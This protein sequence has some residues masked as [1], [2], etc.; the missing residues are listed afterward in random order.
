MDAPSSNGAATEEEMTQSDDNFKVV[1]RIRP[2]LSRELR[3]TGLRPYQ[4]TTYVEPTGRILTLSENL[5]AAISGNNHNAA[6]DS[7]LFA[8][9]RFTFDHVYDQS[10]S[11]E[12]LYTKSA[13]HIVLSI[14][15]GYNAAIIA[16]GQTGTGKTYTMEGEIQGDLRG[17]IPRTV[18]DIFTY[19]VNDPEPS[20]KYLVRAS[21]LQIYN[22]VISDMLKPERTNLIIR[23][24]R[25]RGV[26]V[27]GLSEWVVRSPNEV[28]QLMQRGQS[29][30]INGNEVY[31][32]MQRGQSMRATGATKLNEVSSRSHAVCIIIVEKCVS[33]SRPGQPMDLSASAKEGSYSVKVG[34]LNLVDLA[35]SERVHVTGAVGKRLEESKKINASLSALGNVIAALT[36]RGERS[37][38]PYRDS[39]LTRIL[40]DSLGGNCR[41]TM[42][43]TVAPAMDAF[44]ES[45]STLKFANRAKNI[46][47]EAHVNEDLD[48]RTLLR[49]YE[50]ELR[51]LKAELQRRSR[52]LVDKRALF[53]VEEQKKRAEADKLAALTALEKRSREFLREKEEKRQ[54]EAKIQAMQSQMLVGGA[55]LEDVPAFRAILAREHRRIRDEYE[56]R[57]KELETERQAVEEDRQQVDRYKQLLLKQRDIMIALTARLNERDDQINMLQEELEAYD[58]Y[59]RQLEDT[60]D[61]RTAEIIALRRAALEMHP[62]GE[63]EDRSMFDPA[64]VTNIPDKTSSF[65]AASVSLLGGSLQTADVI[66]LVLEGDPGSAKYLSQEGGMSSSSGGGAAAGAGLLDSDFNGGRGSEGGA[67]KQQTVF[68]MPLTSQRQ[69]SQQG[70]PPASDQ[71]SM[72]GG[73]QPVS[74][75]AENP[76]GP[77][78]L[79]R[80]SALLQLRAENARLSGRLSAATAALQAATEAADNRKQQH[81][82][83]GHVEEVTVNNEQDAERDRDRVVLLTSACLAAQKERSALHQILESKVRRMMEE[84]IQEVQQQG[85][86]GP[87]SAG[88]TYNQHQLVV[89][90]R[91][92]EQVLMKVGEAIRLAPP[93]LPTE[94]DTYV[95]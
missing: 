93:I 43:C 58:K 12:E 33:T 5:Q 4:C 14:L 7:M 85:M 78:A 51:R 92:M 49:K 32:L 86:G 35:G 24:D 19:I 61:G 27:D 62:A 52:D 50:K 90:L 48:Q 69:L 89:R 25:R 2:P 38:V 60:L 20:S 77:E 30:T 83:I 36:A 63:G 88:T 53:E 84:T 76:F 95:E 15:Q 29:M 16:Y 79:E 21:Y 1:I 22:E 87:A 54:L 10:S 42:I 39:K 37:H 67:L 23:E 72:K 55:K 75:A 11:Q 70:F 73:R 6:P 74:I 57:L 18:E 82:S 13:Q 8:T 46:K 41:T 65:S 68:S 80:E 94:E 3:G 40:E 17:I 56:T 45:L 71:L 44:Q 28:Y 9:Y 26:F 59:Q 91:A 81:M 64:D 66:A 47:N 31:Q 34:K